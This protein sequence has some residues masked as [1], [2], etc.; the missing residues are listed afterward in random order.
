L[1]KSNFESTNLAQFSISF[2]KSFI[3]SEQ[4]LS[5][6]EGVVLT[7][8]SEELEKNKGSF[9][10]EKYPVDKVGLP[11]LKEYFSDSKLSQKDIILGQNRI[12]A[13]YF[14]GAIPSLQGVIQQNVILLSHNGYAYKIQMSY[15]SEERK[16]LLD[17]EFRNV[18]STIKFL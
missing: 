5:G 7:L 4:L 15:V 18:S 9:I 12:R 1:D 16:E 6:G 14:T 17:E 8:N 2:P 10:V 13:T 11:S 3:A